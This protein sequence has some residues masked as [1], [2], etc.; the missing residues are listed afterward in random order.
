[1]LGLAEKLRCY[2]LV[3][4][5]RGSYSLVLQERTTRSIDN[6]VTRG[7]IKLFTQLDQRDGLSLVRFKVR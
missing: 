5:P 6:A 1:M 4:R 3:V 2:F 7:S